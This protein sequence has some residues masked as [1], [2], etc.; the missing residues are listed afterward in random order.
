[1][2]WYVEA[3]IFDREVDES[4]LASKLTK[5]I[6]EPGKCPAVTTKEML[7]PTLPGE[8]VNTDVSLIQSVLSVAEKPDR[9]ARDV[10]NAPKFLPPKKVLALDVGKLKNCDEFAKG[11]SYEKK[12][13]PLQN[14]RHHYCIL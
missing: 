9:I 8:R 10:E 5:S 2:S 7:P 13:F 3:G 1:M 11:I 4:V 14:V 6:A 12:K